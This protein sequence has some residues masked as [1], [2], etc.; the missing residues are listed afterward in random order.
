MICAS[1]TYSPIPPVRIVS[2]EAN[3]T[4]AADPGVAFWVTFENTGGYAIQ[5][6]NH[7]LNFSV[8]ANSSI[9]RQVESPGFAGGSDI[10]GGWTLSPGESFTL[11]GPFPNTKAFTYYVVQPGTVDVNLNLTWTGTTP[12]GLSAAT[13]AFSATTTISAQFTFA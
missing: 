13:T 5:F 1:F 3:K 4:D 6:D 2:V 8:P 7:A 9:F 11:G 12:S 10:T